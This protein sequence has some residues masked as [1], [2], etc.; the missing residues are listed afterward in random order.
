MLDR[1]F[2]DSYSG[3]K[4]WLR[5]LVNGVDRVR[6]T[7]ASRRWLSRQTDD[8]PTGKVTSFEGLGLAYAR[9][10]SR[11]R[12]DKAMTDVFTRYG[13]AFNEAIL[14]HGLGD[15]AV[16]WGF[17]RAQLELFEAAG[18]EGR[19]CVLDQTIAPS[20]VHHALLAAEHARWPGWQEAPPTQPDR[21]VAERERCEWTA[22]DRIF[23][24]SEFV[25]ES[26]VAAGGPAE[27]CVLV[28]YATDGGRFPPRPTRRP[29]EGRPLRVL[30]AGEVGLRKG[31][32]YVLEALRRLGPE[33]AEGRLVG[34]IR[35]DRRNLEAYAE[36]AT[37][38][39]S[40][41]RPEMRAHYAWADLFVFP[42]VCEGSAA[43]LSEALASG[44]PVI[45][46]PNSGPPPCN[47][48]LRTVPAGDV[49]AIAEAIVA[50][51]Q[52]YERAQPPLDPDPPFGLR[53]YGERMVQAVTELAPA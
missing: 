31:V 9:A 6:P 3:N 37:F 28:P 1:L 15:A 49:D 10:R 41:P 25:R 22:V 27:K 45:C 51:G 18:R 39:G 16:V 13:K 50:V 26:V 52:D 2:T 36:V 23:C 14:R 11:E 53:A 40:V 43:V 46:T 19:R 33:T 4:P 21:A 34:P 42:S 29:P 30:F 32:P 44:L 12:R 24:P 8:L 47:G 7:E 17:N 20:P 35:I 5:R 48:G 38:T